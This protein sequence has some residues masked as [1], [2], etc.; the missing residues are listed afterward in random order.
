MSDG[1]PL[2]TEVRGNLSF[3]IMNSLFIIDQAHLTR[4]QEISVVITSLSYTVLAIISLF[5]FVISCAP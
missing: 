3:R 2:R 5:G 1:M 4:N